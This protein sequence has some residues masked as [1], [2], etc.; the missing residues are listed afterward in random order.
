MSLLAENS[1]ALRT[2]Y[3]ELFNCRFF[4]HFSKGI[5]SRGKL[6]KGKRPIKN[7]KQ[8]HPRQRW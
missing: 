6:G 4:E 1:L 3:P 2:V 5:A 8:K 7:T